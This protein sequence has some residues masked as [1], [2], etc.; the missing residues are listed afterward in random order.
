MSI[1]NLDQFHP[2]FEKNRRILHKK[3]SPWILGSTCGAEYP[4]FIIV[5]CLRDNP[6]PSEINGVKIK[7]MEFNSEAEYQEIMHE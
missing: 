4:G 2:V 6:I 7:K 3:Y 5:H 1:V